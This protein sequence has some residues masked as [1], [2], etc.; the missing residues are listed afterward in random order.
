LAGAAGAA[1]AAGVAVCALAAACISTSA[2]ARASGLIFEGHACMESLLW[3]VLQVEK[4]G[5]EGIWNADFE[6]VAIDCMTG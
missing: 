5:F 2:A 6:V 4:T 3:G 1:G